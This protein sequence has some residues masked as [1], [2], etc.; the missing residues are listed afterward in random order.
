MRGNKLLLLLLFFFTIQ[1]AFAQK[2]KREPLKHEQEVRDMVAFFQYMLNTLGDATTSNRDKDVMVMESYTKIFRD[3]KVQVEDDLDPDRKVITNKDITAYL[4]DVDFFFKDVKFEFNI[5]H[6]EA[7][8][9]SGDKLYY[10]V[11]LSRNLHGTTADGKPMRNTMKRFIEINYDTKAQDLKIV[12]IYTNQFN[13]KQAL[14]DWWNSLSYEW[15]S[16]FTEKFSLA[17][18]AQLSDIRKVM[19]T[20]SLDIS[21]NHYV[22]NIEPLAELNDLRYLNLSGTAIADLSPL[23]NLTE[24]SDVDISKTQIKDLSPLR[25]AVNLSRLNMSET[26]IDSIRVLERF[27]NLKV[28][29]MKESMSRD[30]SVLKNLDSVAVLDLEKANIV[31]VDFAGAL[32]NL[33]SLNIA[34]TAVA[35]ISVIKDLSNLSLL[36]IDST[37]VKDITVLSNLKK[38]RVVHMNYTPVK[39]LAALNG[40]PVLERVYCDHTGVTRVEANEFTTKNPT[41]LVISD[42][43]DLRGWWTDLPSVWKDVF[44]RRAKIGYNPGKEDLAKVANLDSINISNYVNIK[45]LAPLSR[46]QKLRVLIVAKTGIVDVIPLKFNPLL[47]MIDISNTS[48]SDISPLANLQNLT[49]LSA[50][51]TTVGSIDTL[52]RLKGLERLYVDQTQVNDS[53]VSKFLQA[54]PHCL[55]VYKTNQLQTWWSSLSPEWQS[56]FQN[57]LRIEIQ[58]TRNNFHKLIE[59]EKLSLHN[60]RVTDLSPLTEF[61]RLKELEI[62]GT[63]VTDLSPLSDMTSLHSLVVRDQP[64]RGLGALRNLRELK[65][66]DISNTAIDELDVVSDLKKLKSLSCAGT[67]VKKLNPLQSLN[68][69]EQLDCSNTD[70]R[71]LEPIFHLPLKTLKCYNSKVSKGDLEKFKKFNPECNVI[72]YR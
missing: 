39:S 4:K 34:R 44:S 54:N 53:I 10:K 7:A 57:Q 27:T 71:N 18:S 70:I 50:D 35:D 16:I 22:R 64:I 14:L 36:N 65:T 32:K 1:F 48:V 6:I 3:A 9:S 61:I 31:S 37:Q 68:M 43:E 72:F 69:L 2:G 62:T 5:D 28:L 13:E 42:S 55:V 26:S 8:G 56:V 41:T 19:S 33:N 21:D 49:T 40:L 58:P 25:Y 45:T 66:L 52:S 17:D 20:D 38:L 46:L 60:V 63:D 30:F 15:K 24:L 29:E 59:A 47:E 23:R 12:S 51:G 11:S 67:P